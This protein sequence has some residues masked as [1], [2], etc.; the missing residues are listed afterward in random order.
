MPN[1]TLRL[2]DELHA[3]LVAAAGRSGR[4]LQREIIVRLDGRA[5]L[6]TGEGERVVPTGGQLGAASAD[7]S[8]SPVTSPRPFRGP[9]PKGGAK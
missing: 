4:S 7:L 6:V 9:D 5:G 3:E 2:S 1:L 8:T